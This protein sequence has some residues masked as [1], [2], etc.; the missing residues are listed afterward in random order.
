[1]SPPGTEG[2]DLWSAREDI[3]G[4][5]TTAMRAEWGEAGGQFLA[6]QGLVA[7]RMRGREGAQARFQERIEG[8]VAFQRG[9]SEESFVER[10]GLTLA[11]IRGGL[12]G[13]RAAQDASN[14]GPGSRQRQA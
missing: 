9:D 12:E 7:R 4:D 3:V 5:A 13:A 14:L 11:S 10:V 8:G 1:M 6:K 2:A